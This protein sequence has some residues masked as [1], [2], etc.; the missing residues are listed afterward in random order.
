MSKKEKFIE[1][2]E[3][4]IDKLSISAVE[5]LEELKSSKDKDITT[6]KGKVI[7]KFMQD[8]YDKYNNT[9]K[10]QDIGKSLETSGRSVAGS[11]KKLIVDK[12]VEKVGE[13]PI[14][15]KLTEAG[16]NLTL[17]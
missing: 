11:M 15:Y 2:V 7:L 16:K 10:A 12:Y 13:K 17:D 8:N 6:K 3:C 4:F 1:E 14:S 5:Y 9:Y